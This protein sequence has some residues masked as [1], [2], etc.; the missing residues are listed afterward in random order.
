MKTRLAAVTAVLLLAL[1]GCA[2]NPD[3][4]GDEPTAPAVAESPAAAPATVEPTDS[5]EVDVEKYFLESGLVSQIELSDEEK[6]AAGHY[7]CEQVEAGNLEVV[8]IEG[9]DAGINRAYVADATVILCPE[10][11]ETYAVY[12]DGAGG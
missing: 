2:G 1:T 6:L 7:A 4:A 12:R 5:E 11:A 8:A 10:L 9:L 3:S